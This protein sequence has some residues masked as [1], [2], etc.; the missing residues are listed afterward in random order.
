MFQ[1]FRYILVACILG[2]ALIGCSPYKTI[3][4]DDLREILTESIMRQS[5][6]KVENQRSVTLDSLDYHSDILA[7]YGYTIEDFGYTIESMAR[8]KSNPLENILDTVSSDIARMAIIAEYK[9]NVMKRYNE[10]A[11][12]EYRDTLLVEDTIVAKDQR[13]WRRVLLRDSVMQGDYELKVTYKTMSDYRYPQKSIRYYTRDTTEGA[14]S[15]KTLWLSRSINP[16][17]VSVRFSV[18]QEARDSLVLYFEANRASYVTEKVLRSLSNDTSYISRIELTYTPFLEK[19][20]KDFYQT[21]FAND[22]A[23]NRNYDTVRFDTTLHPP[24]VMQ[25][26]TTYLIKNEESTQ[27]SSATSI[28]QQWAFFTPSDS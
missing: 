17:T 18:E 27:D 9:Y 15:A 2:C 6:L 4:E 23:I 20:R 1:Y 24:R 13:G 14:I 12:S 28:E 22:F 16:R 5:L 19:A 11:L 3:P 21:L 8:L 10:A 25:I 26:D 7:R